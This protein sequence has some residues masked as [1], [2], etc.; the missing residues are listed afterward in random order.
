MT[1]TT[2][3]PKVL[4]WWHAAPRIRVPACDCV[5]QEESEEQI[6]FSAG[7]LEWKIELA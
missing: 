2:T 1:T 4:S 5:W 3:T 6:Q 7:R